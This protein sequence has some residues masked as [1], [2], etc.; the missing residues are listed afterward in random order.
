MKRILLVLCLSLIFQPSLADDCDFDQETRIEENVKLKNVYPGSYLIEENLILVIPVEE[1]EVRINIGGC[2]H[3]GVN[4]ELRTKDNE[5]YKSENKF[6]EKI[7]YL[8]N[9]Y[10]QGYIDSDKLK[11]IIKNKKWKKTQPSI[12]YY[13]LE[14]DDI[15][16]FE[17]YQNADGEYT[18]IGFNNY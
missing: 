13:L 16:T 17:V 9:V 6:M 18:V 12:R 14:Y 3:Y 4:V 10:S 1:G 11:S 7:L 8:V 5:K 2:V 15:S